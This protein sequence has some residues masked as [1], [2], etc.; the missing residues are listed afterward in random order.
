MCNTGA[1]IQNNSFPN[2]TSL[3]FLVS[4]NK[5]LPFPPRYH[6]CQILIIR[7]PPLRR[8]PHQHCQ[9]P[10][11]SHTHSL[12]PSSS[13][14]SP[15]SSTSV[16]LPS[17]PPKPQSSLLAQLRRSPISPSSPSFVSCSS[18][19]AVITASHSLQKSLLLRSTSITKLRFCL[20]RNNVRSRSLTSRPPIPHCA[21]LRRGVLRR[22]CVSQHSLIVVQ[23]AGA[24][25]A[26]APGRRML[27]AVLFCL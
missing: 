23:R 22:L 26:H 24:H 16:S 13:S 7:H 2:A 6:H 27:C 10:P 25:L 8:P 19:A 9:S 4:I 17:L 3:P 18:A 20:I 15:S 11:R 5:R 14:P 21:P 1:S 12:S